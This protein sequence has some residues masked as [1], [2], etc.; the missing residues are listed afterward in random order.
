MQQINRNIDL[1]RYQLCGDDMLLLE[2]VNATEASTSAKDSDASVK[3]APTPQSKVRKDKTHVQRL[4]EAS[5]E[6]RSL[7]DDTRDFMLSL[8]DDVQEKT[9][10]LYAAFKRIKNFASVVVQ[11]GHSACLKVYLKLEPSTVT[12]EPGFSRDVSNIGHWGTGDIEL[13]L[14]NAEHL[15]KAKPLIEKSFLRN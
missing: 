1:L 6:L 5:A 4:S 15:E 13:T 10:V 9:L 11:T 8:G 2:L 14:E 3:G 12:F 7:F